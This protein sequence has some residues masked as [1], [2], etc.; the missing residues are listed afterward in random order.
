MKEQLFRRFPFRIPVI[1]GL[2]F[3]DTDRGAGQV[4]VGHDRQDAREPFQI[5]LIMQEDGVQQFLAG[6]G[7]ILFIGPDQVFAGLFF[8]PAR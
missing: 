2:G 6:I 5:R 3:S 8:R 4:L 7:N 1:I